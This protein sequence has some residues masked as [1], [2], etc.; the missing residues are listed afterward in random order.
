M[1]VTAVELADITDTDSKE[2]Q[3]A[4]TAVD[5]ICYERVPSKLNILHQV[6]Y[7][8]VKKEESYPGPCLASAWWDLTRNVYRSRA[9]LGAAHL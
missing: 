1:K 3:D 5:N 2:E 6:L 4:A 9:L 7:V 8:F